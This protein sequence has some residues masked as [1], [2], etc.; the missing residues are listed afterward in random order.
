M[1]KYSEKTSTV[2]TTQTN[3]RCPDYREKKEDEVNKII[4]EIQIVTSKSLDKD[5]INQ[6]E[7]LFGDITEILDD[8]YVDTKTPVFEKQK[9]ILKKFLNFEY[10]KNFLNEV[11]E[12]SIM[13]EEDF[14]VAFKEDFKY[15][16]Q[17]VVSK[18]NA[19]D[20]LTPDPKKFLDIEYCKKDI[21]YCKKVL[22]SI[23][24]K[25]KNIKNNR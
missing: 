2:S 1:S 23:M 22:I 9:N 3:L 19:H 21:E 7:N 17:K 12:I 15:K 4:A 20:K 5:L 25:V 6:L 13:Y 11:L 18:I 24:K 10:C 16:I 8:E 14:T